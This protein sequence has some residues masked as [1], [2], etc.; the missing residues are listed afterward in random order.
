MS[1]FGCGHSFLG[2]THSPAHWRFIYF[3]YTFRSASSPS[4]M[5]LLLRH[6]IQLIFV[7]SARS[8]I[9][10]WGL[11]GEQRTMVEWN[12][13]GGIILQKD[14][15]IFYKSLLLTAYSILVIPMQ[16]PIY[17]NIRMPFAYT[18]TLTHRRTRD[19]YEIKISIYH[20]HSILSQ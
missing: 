8:R 7:F 12:F 1:S 9:Q 18:H 15:H 16:S 20:S 3:S 13:L 17:F 2:I 10:S 4:S 11:A 14:F 6:S 5:L 19:Q